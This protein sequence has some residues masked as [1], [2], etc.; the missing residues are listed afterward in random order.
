MYPLRGLDLELRPVILDDLAGLREGPL[1]V[2]HLLGD[3][4]QGR[5]YPEVREEELRLREAHAR[6]A[7]EH[8]DLLEV[9]ERAHLD[10]VALGDHRRDPA[11]ADGV[12]E[13]GDG[14]VDAAVLEVER[15][16]ADGDEALLHEVVRYCSN[17]Q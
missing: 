7:V 1:H 10:Q 3:E 14:R 12:L 17:R 6:A 4:V 16:L 5:I 9:R 8:V 13:N 11:L 15:E 2:A